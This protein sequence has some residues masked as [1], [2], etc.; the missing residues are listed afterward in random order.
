MTMPNSTT[1]PAGTCAPSHINPMDPPS[2]FTADL[3]GYCGFSFD[4]PSSMGTL[5]NMTHCCA[6]E[7]AYNANGCFQFCEAAEEGFKECLVEDVFGGKNQTEVTIM[8]N[9]VAMGKALAP[10]ESL[11]MREGGE[12]VWWKIR[13]AAAVL[14][15]VQTLW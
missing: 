6:S 13:I 5:M 8:C 14:V 15:G 9:D 12:V 3:V 7:A 1:P 2:W 4:H 10:G 11:G